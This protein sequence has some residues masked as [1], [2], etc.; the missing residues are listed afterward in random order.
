MTEKNY[1]L[2]PEQEAAVAH[3][4]QVIRRGVAEIVP[5]EDLVAKLRRSVATG[6]P[7]RIKLGLDPTAPDIHLGH[8][9]VLQKIRQ[10]QDLGHV[11]HLVIGNFT[12]QIGDP[13]DKSETRRQLSPEEVQENAKT[14]VAQ[15]F[16]VLDETKTEVVYNADWLA[17]LTFADVVRLASTLTV[18]RMLEREDFHKRFAENRPIHI[19]EFFYP[20]MQ[21]YDSVHLHTDIELGGTD[22]K[23]NLLMGRT[24]QR[25]FGQEQQVALMMPL[26][27]GLDGVHKMSK[28]LG[29]YI[30][31]AEDPHT[32]FGK[33][34]S[35]PDELMPR[36][37]ELVS[38]VPLDEL[39]RIQAGLRDGSLHPR[40]AKMRLASELVRRFHG[41]EAS[42]QAVARWQQVF[43]AGGLPE[44][45]PEATVATPRVWIVELLVQLGLA[46]SRSEARR[47]VEQGGVRLDGERVD[48]VNAEIDVRDG[49]VIQVGKRRF[50]RCRLNA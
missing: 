2:T 43:Q 37:F 13:T 46:A 50:V 23:F 11:A 39:A 30:G 32:M 22:Q 48:D 49:M 1:V 36:Y 20:L 3:Q 42:R 44:D 9:V 28:S 14:Y 4:L 25:E 38:E 26:L 29:N 40:D 24:L 18:A 35:I 5:E 6:Q 12:G 41:E 31:V 8:T 17:P 33:A 15:I 7:L 45:I 19:H 21:A 10:L 47:F 16:K 34:M 27:E